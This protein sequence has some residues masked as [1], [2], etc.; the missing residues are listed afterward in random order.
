VTD[1]S[2]VVNLHREGRLAIPALRSAAR[3]VAAAPDLA[4]EIVAVLDRADAATERAVAASGVA[5]R[6]AACDFGDPALARNDGVAQAQGRY[7]AFLDG[8]D[9]MGEN[10]LDVAT[11][12]LRAREGRDVIAHPRLNY[13]FGRDGEPVAWI[14]PDME[15][16]ALDSI[17][18][19]A[20]NFWT[21]ASFAP[22]ALHRRFP[23]PAN[24]LE[25]GLGHE[26]WAFNLATVEAGVVHIAPEGTVHFIRRRQSGR[27]AQS[28]AGRLLPNLALVGG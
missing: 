10:W 12:A 26:D 6:R 18:L 9:L 2:V 8:D 22:A 14:H 11:S 7:V 21:S 5:L 19:R 15:S 24:A 16:E 17:L 1:V 23:F 13:V 25:A 3:A 20:G 28:Q 27:L 4:C